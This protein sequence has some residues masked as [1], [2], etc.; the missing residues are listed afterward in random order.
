MQSYPQ[1]ALTGGA[2]ILAHAVVLAVLI[3]PPTTTQPR[4]QAQDMTA[5]LIEVA[6]QSATWDTVSLPDIQLVTPTLDADSLKIVSFEDPEEDS[7]VVGS[8]SSPRLSRVQSVRP[9]FFARKA[10]VQRP[11]TVV[12]AVLVLADGRVGDV[13]VTRSSGSAAADAAAIEYARMLRWI[14]GTKDHRPQ[15]MRISFPVILSLSD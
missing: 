14:P 6:D 8:A 4:R 9:E 10:G 13:Q 5:T 15:A 3:N 2:V 11:Q 1:R 7:G 12:L